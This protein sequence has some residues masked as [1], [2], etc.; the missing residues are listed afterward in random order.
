[1]SNV[2][3]HGDAAQRQAG[4]LLEDA[5]ERNRLLDRHAALRERQQLPRQLPR[6]HAGLLRLGKSQCRC[7]GRRGIVTRAI[8][9]LP[10]IAIRMLLKSWAMPP[11]SRPSEASLPARARSSC[12]LQRVADVAERH[13]HPDGAPG[14]IAERRRASPQSAARSGRARRAPCSARRPSLPRLR[15]A[16]RRRCRTASASRGST[17]RNTEASGWPMRLA[18]ASSP[19]A[20]PPCC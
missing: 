4:A 10:M 1:M 16:R 2:Q 11:A 13:H 7:A 15:R 20:L 17:L 14:G 19:S 18:R 9:T 6:T 8:E 3:R 5:R 12:A